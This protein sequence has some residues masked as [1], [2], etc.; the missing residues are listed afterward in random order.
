MTVRLAVR[1]TGKRAGQE[2]VQLYVEPAELAPGEPPRTL[3]A[4]RKVGFPAGAQRE[5]TLTLDPR[6]FSFYDLKAGGWRIRPGAYRVLAG[7]SS[8]DIRQTGAINIV[9]EPAS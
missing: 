8:D 5:V 1:N 7:A 9:E 6:A 2:V 4:F 3:R